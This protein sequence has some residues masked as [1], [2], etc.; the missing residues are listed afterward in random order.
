M[1]HG[2]IAEER[3]E[4]LF[5]KAEE[6]FDEDSEL[7]NRYVEIAQRIGERT[8]TPV[9]KKFRRMFCSRCGSFLRPGVNCQIRIDSKDGAVEYKCGECGKEDCYEY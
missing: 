7:A 8:E 2:K 6:K 1:Q 3:M 5:E 4:I 9:P